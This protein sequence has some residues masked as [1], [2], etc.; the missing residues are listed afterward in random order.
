MKYN[1]DWHSAITDLPILK[2]GLS[3]LVTIQYTTGEET[4]VEFTE[5]TFITLDGDDETK[6][7]KGWKYF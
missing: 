6:H 7:L 4:V 3:K 5:L 2:N 1:H